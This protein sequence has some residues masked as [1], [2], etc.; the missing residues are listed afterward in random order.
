MG[1]TSVNDRRNR[2]RGSAAKCAALQRVCDVLHQTA[3]LRLGRR[4]VALENAAVAADQEF[5]EIPGDVAGDS[6]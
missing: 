1:R 2:N 5:L 4:R 6:L 3:V